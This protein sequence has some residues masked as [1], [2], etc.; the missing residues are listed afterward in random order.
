MKKEAIFKLWT[1]INID[2]TAVLFYFRLWVQ[3]SPAVVCCVRVCWSYIMISG[4]SQFRFLW[5]IPAYD[6]GPCLVVMPRGCFETCCYSYLTLFS[7][8]NTFNHHIII[9]NFHLR[10]G[11]AHLISFRLSGAKG[12][13]QD[14]GFSVLFTPLCVPDHLKESDKTHTFRF[15]AN[16]CKQYFTILHFSVQLFEWMN[17]IIHL[18]NEVL[19][20]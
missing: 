20:P 7:A 5:I 4:T 10:P 11:S 18:I 16:S 2:S 15:Y 14:G 13:K 9:K 3:S 17:E 8:S 6:Y 19:F 1:A 12:M